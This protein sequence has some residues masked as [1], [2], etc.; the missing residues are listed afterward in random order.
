MCRKVS[1]F[2]KIVNSG[3]RKLLLFQSI[4]TQH[5]LE[6]DLSGEAAEEM[7]AFAGTGPAVPCAAVPRVA[8]PLAAVPHMVPAVAG[9]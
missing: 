6:L 1:Q 5:A 9:G 4:S 7:M 8:V 3:E 2:Y